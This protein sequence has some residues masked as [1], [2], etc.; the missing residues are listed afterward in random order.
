MKGWEL[1]SWQE[2]GQWVFAVLMGTNRLKKAEEIKRA[3]LSGFDALQRTLEQLA[4]GQ[5]V[6]WV[7]R[8]AAKRAAQP[9]L[10]F[11]ETPPKDIVG[12]VKRWCGDMQLSL[13]LLSQ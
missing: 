11:L 1:Y 5:S 2:D 13:G 8:E 10:A 9:E 12:Q 7:S 4:R 6:V 3:K